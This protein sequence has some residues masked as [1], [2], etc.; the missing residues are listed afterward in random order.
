[1]A[2]DKLPQAL[3]VIYGMSKMLQRLD[4]WRS[5]TSRLA[6]MMVREQSAPFHLDCFNILRLV[7]LCP[8]DMCSFQVCLLCHRPHFVLLRNV[9][10][11]L[12]DTFSP[13]ISEAGNASCLEA[14]V[15]GFRNETRHGAESM[16][17]RST[18]YYERLRSHLSRDMWWLS[19]AV[20]II[21]VAESRK[22][23]DFPLA[24]STFNIIFEVV[25]A[26]SFVGVSVGYPGKTYAFCGEWTSFSKLLLIM[27]S[28]VGRHR[29]VP[30]MIMKKPR[31]VNIDQTVHRQTIAPGCDLELVPA[32]ARLD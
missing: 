15:A 32:H 6:I 9:L 28:V 2:I 12:R 25:S 29:D 1:M 30:N 7:S 11:S 4:S 22:F 14:G 18:F 17:C 3:L 20:I 24:F 26:Y 21:C 23:I 10:T 5:L 19:F 16:L 31:F 13:Q 8:S 27:I